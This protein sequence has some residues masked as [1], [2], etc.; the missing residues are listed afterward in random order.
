MGAND[1][2]DWAAWSGEAVQ[3][4]Q[5]RNRAFIEKFDL[6]NRPYRWS[7][8]QG[9]IA[10]PTAADVV[11]A[12]LCVV[13]SVSVC[14]GTFLWAWENETIPVQA[15]RRLEEVR[16]FGA[17]HELALLTT[18]EWRG[19]RA[20]GVEMVAVAGRV[21]DAEGVWIAPEGDVTLF[22]TLHRFRV[23]RLS[24]VAWLSPE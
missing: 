17:K 13:G 24:E 6:S 20:E 16:T 8:E 14:E 9:Q 15:R 12:D 11:V 2:R 3:I 7:L 5:T 19:G 10:F 4:M 18:G 1:E 23:Q 22:F 21:L